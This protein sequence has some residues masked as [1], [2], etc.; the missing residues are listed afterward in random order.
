MTWALVAAGVVAGVV[1]GWLAGRRGRAEPL[2]LSAERDR[3]ASQLALRQDLLLAALAAM[4]AGAVVL[5]RAGRMTRIE[6]RA[7]ELLGL[8][9]PGEGRPLGEAARLPGVADMVARAGAEPAKLEVE[10]PGSPGTV[11][12]AR[13]APLPGAEGRILLLN[14][15]SERRRLEEVL[16]D[17][18]ANASHELRTPVTVLRASA[19]ALADG[20]LEEPEVAGRLVEAIQRNSVRLSDLLSDL[21]DLSRLEAGRFVPEPTVVPLA[22]AIQRVADAVR[23][24]A[25]ERGITLQIE[26]PGDL[27]G[28]ADPGALHQALLNL[29]DN[30]VKYTPSGGSVVLRAMP[31]EAGTR[32]E[33]VDDGPGIPPEHRGRVFERFYR[34]DPGRSR[35]MGGTGLG[36][37]IVR[38]L[39]RAMGGEV[40]LEPVLPHGCRFRVDLPP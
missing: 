9:G 2:D 31:W 29:A 26:A 22:D 12:L 36:L 23:Q 27:E 10:L 25:I 34:V 1:C 20:A 17:F 14:D 21:L 15:V 19:E 3:L 33:V 16:R 6:G 7:A 28:F 35:E 40:G 37:A 8:D 30:A 4:R 18:V 11:V 13:T 39:V 24:R 32:I 38:L 5:D